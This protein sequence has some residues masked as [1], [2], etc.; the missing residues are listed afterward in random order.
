V[1]SGRSIDRMTLGQRQARSPAREAAVRGP[2][3]GTSRPV[4]SSTRPATRARFIIRVAVL[5]LTPSSSETSLSGPSL[6]A[7]PPNAGE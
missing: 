3:R 5:M 2:E 6:S 4:A 1:I 7:L